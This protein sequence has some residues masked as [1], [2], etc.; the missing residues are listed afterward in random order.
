MLGVLVGCCLEMYSR[1]CE[2]CLVSL[3]VEEALRMLAVS[4]HEELLI[5][6]HIVAPS[7]QP[8][9]SN[10]TGNLEIS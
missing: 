3:C 10:L 5:L 1:S 7:G 9:V 2:C 6:L 4:L 8:L